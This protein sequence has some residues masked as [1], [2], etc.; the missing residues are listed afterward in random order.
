MSIGKIL[1]DLSSELDRS[2]IEDTLEV[3][4]DYDE[5]LVTSYVLGKRSVLHRINNHLNIARARL[6][7]QKLKEAEGAVSLAQ[8]KIISLL[9][10]CQKEGDE[11]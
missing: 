2:T 4:M 10:V 9:K 6:F 5:D 8:D 7:E 1:E 11:R 3:L